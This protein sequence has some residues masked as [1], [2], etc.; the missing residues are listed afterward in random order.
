M[1]N[2]IV[3]IEG[4]GYKKNTEL[5]WNLEVVDEGLYSIL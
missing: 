3:L 1:S 5:L 4:K 2:Y